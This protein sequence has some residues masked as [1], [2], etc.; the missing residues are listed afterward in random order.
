[1]L[2]SLKLE[3]FLHYASR[4]NQDLYPAQYLMLGLGIIAILLAFFRTN[5]SS[6][7]ISAILAFFYGWVGIQFYLV[8]FKEFMPVPM[9]F[10]SLFIAQAL[11]FIFEGSVRN[12]ISFEVKANIYGLTGALLIF[13]AIFG[14][15]ALEY[16]LGRGYPE[17]LSFGMFPCPTVIFSLGILLWTKKKFPGYILIFPIINALSGFIPVFMIGIIEDIGLIIS[18]LLTLSLLGSRDKY[19]IFRKIKKEGP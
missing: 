2:D 15:Q 13:Y 18:G 11:I 14:Y 17:I 8:F 19:L 12:R 1:M 4:Y 9:V 3:N 6:R 10:G 7:S 16:I 5:R